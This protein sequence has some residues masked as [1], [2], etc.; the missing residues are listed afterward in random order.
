[1]RFYPTSMLRNNIGATDL[2]IPL[3]DV[4]G[5]PEAGLIKIG[6]ELI[7]YL[8]VDTANN[9]LIVPGPGSGDGAHLQLQSNNEY[10][11]PSGTNIGQGTMND[12]SLV[13]TTAANDNWKVICVYIE[14]DANRNPIPATAKFEVIGE[15]S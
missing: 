6:I 15:F 1:V 8:A 3:V 4:E 5:F 11:I 7:L 2:I 13:S 9:N 10:Y 12:L 14:Q